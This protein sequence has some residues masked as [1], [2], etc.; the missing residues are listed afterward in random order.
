MI[1]PEFAGEI[2]YAP[3][4]AG[5]SCSVVKDVKPAAEIVADLMR[6][7]RAALPTA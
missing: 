3:M 4:W 1:T 6:D 7:A 5:E 2:E